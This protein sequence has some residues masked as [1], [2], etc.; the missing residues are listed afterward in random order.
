[1]DDKST[2]SANARDV[3]GRTTQQL[4]PHLL[5]VDDDRELCEVL[6]RYLEAEDFRVSFA[7][8]GESGTKAGIE[9]SF[10]LIVLDVMLPDEKGF[11]VLEDIRHRAGTSVLNLTAR[12][13]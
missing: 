13:Q 11:N 7:H 1:M 8:T 4:K 12:S 2:T 6:K 5:I 3:A 9:G 10:E